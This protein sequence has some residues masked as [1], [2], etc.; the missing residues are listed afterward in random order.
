MLH[1]RTWIPINSWEVE[2]TTS[3]STATA[4]AATTTTWLFLT[5]EAYSTVLSLLAG[6]GEFQNPPKQIVNDWLRPTESQVK[7][8]GGGGEEGCVLQSISSDQ[9]KV[10]KG[11]F[12][13][14]VYECVFLASQAKPRLFKKIKAKHAMQTATFSIENCKRID[15]NCLRKQGSRNRCLHLMQR[16]SLLR[17][18]K[19]FLIRQL[20]I[21]S[22]Y[23]FFIHFNVRINNNV[24]INVPI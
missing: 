18:R 19:Q 15:W 1:R 23:I 14:A 22:I 5:A 20:C 4:V 24:N 10:R 11:A 6:S 12:T 21:D 8:Q 13:L 16:E 9:K 2:T 3:T 7:A 17:I